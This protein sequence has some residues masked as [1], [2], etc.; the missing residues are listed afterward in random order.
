M[1]GGVYQLDSA[2][3]G[4]AVFAVSVIV[5]YVLWSMFLRL[6]ESLFSKS[7]FY[8]I[9]KVLRDIGRSVLLAIVLV[10]TYLGISIYDPAVLGGVAAKVWG[11]LMIMVLAEI[12][13]RVLLG[14][15]DVYGAKKKA[16]RTFLSQKTPLLKQI[17][18]LLI[19][20]AAVLLII[21]YLSYEIGFIVTIMGGLFLVFAFIMYQGRLR[22]IMAGLQ[23]ADRVNKGDYVEIGG[24]GGF[25][26]RILDQY[27]ILRDIDGKSVTV[28]NS[29]F[30]NGVVR[31]SFLLDGNLFCMR[32]ALSGKG[33]AKDKEKLSAVCGRMA[34]GLEGV[35]DDYKPRVFFSG[36]EGGSRIFVVRFIVLQNADVRKVLDSFS[37]SIGAEF[38]DRVSEIRLE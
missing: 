6:T 36:A 28:P 5:L 21:N 12:V 29:E 1:I 27:T 24:K 22:N 30:N 2:V 35:F 33:S 19:Y 37:S 14:V 11:I 26:E 10:G 8:F 32:V 34:L 17:V 38:G 3:L 7:K 13:A 15:L 4:V 31:N 16:A 23:L 25:V 18:V 20:G 9:P